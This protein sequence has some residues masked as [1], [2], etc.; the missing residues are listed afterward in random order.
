MLFIVSFVGSLVVGKCIHELYS[1]KDLKLSSGV[2]HEIVRDYGYERRPPF[3]AKVANPNFIKPEGLGVDH[4]E[5]VKAK[6]RRAA[7]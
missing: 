3:V 2:K 4:E 6:E 7:H 1:D 5:W